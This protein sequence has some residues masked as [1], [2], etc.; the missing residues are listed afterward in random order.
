[1]GTRS[2]REERL[3]R[4]GRDELSGILKTFVV[5]GRGGNELRPEG[6]GTTWEDA[7]IERL[8]DLAELGSEGGDKLDRM[9][10]LPTESD[11]RRVTGTWTKCAAWAAIISAVLG[12]LL[13]MLNLWDRFHRG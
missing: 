11:R 7:N 13:L 5:R 6:G 1:M 10:S 2:E 8:L 4:L 3:R 9:L 12:A